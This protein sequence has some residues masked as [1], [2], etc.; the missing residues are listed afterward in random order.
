VFSLSKTFPVAHARVGMR[1]SRI[2]TDDTLSAYNKPG[3]MYTNR[4][5]ASLGIRFLT[6]FS[7]DYIYKKYRAAQLEYCKITKTQPSNTVIFGIG[8][9]KYQ[10]YNRGTDTNRLSFHRYLGDCE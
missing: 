9:K 3:L 5:A 10:K 7:S 8:D 4:L 6:K 1:L 2:D